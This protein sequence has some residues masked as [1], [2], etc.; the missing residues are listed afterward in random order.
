MVG[1]GFGC[2]VI[3]CNEN[4]L[5]APKLLH[6]SS[7]FNIQHSTLFTLLFVLLVRFQYLFNQPVADDVGFVEVY[8]ADAFYPVQQLH[9]LLQARFA[10]ARQVD[11]R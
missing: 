10:A 7:S 2:R 1:T 4:N 3:S 8:E 11:L 6:P 5:G 9:G